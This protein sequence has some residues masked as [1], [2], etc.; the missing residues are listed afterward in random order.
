MQICLEMKLKDLCIVIEKIPYQ[1]ENVSFYCLFSTTI[2]LVVVLLDVHLII[3]K[4]HT[5]H[6]TWKIS[7]YTL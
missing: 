1:L 2:S 4:T 3:T 7:S 6:K 5:F